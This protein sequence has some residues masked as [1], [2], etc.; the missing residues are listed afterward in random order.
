MGKETNN[1]YEFGRYRL[2]VENRT[3]FRDEQAVALPPKA[4]EL[5]AVLVER[6]GEVI[7]KERL[8]NRVWPDSFVEDANLTQN[9]FLLRKVFAEDSGRQTYIETIPRRGYRFVADVRSPAPSPLLRK[10]DPPQSPTIITKHTITQ[11]ITEAEADDTDDPGALSEELAGANSRMRLTGGRQS[12]WKVRSLR[13][14]L[15]ILLLSAVGV[16]LLISFTRP[17]H[18]GVKTVVVLPFKSLDANEGDPAMGLKLADALI[19]RLGHLRQI[20]VRPTRA[21]QKYEG[22]LSDPLVAGR[23]QQVDAVLDGSFQRAG[24]RLRLR[25]QLLRTSDGSQLWARTFDEPASDPFYL[26]DA[27][28]EQ[29]AQA[30][31]P[32]LAGAERQLVTRHDT[33]SVEAHRLYTEGR[34]YWNRRNIE[35]LQ[36]SVVYFEQAIKLD[37][38]Y[39]R[40]YAGLADSYSV[41]SDFDILRPGEAYPKIKDAALKAL[42][43]D[44]TLVEAHTSLAMLKA[45]YEW[46]WRGA[47]QAFR[48]AL[49]LN[50][51]YPTAHQWYS[52]YLA[53]MGRHEEALDEIRHAEELD[54]LSLIIRSVEAWIWYQAR[55]YDRT[56]EKCEKVLEMD[57]NFSLPYAYLGCAYERKGMYREAAEANRKRV[58]F[59]GGAGSAKPTA[60]APTSLTAKEYW[61]ARFEI[62]KPIGAAFDAAEAFAQL[63]QADQAIEMLEQAYAE[64]AY[65]LM[66]LKVHPN[67][68]PLRADPRFRDLLRRV[69]L[70]P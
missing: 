14:A 51:N 70:E 27:L 67:L 28:A 65:R 32:Q 11:I 41:M 64:H 49:E 25:V 19:Q 17:R 63:G 42:A 66:Y 16:G 20:V 37:P 38:N 22:Q 30:L 43:I 29:T 2:D 9:I 31:V 10:I 24:E 26:Q 45:S 47:E 54:P 40:A 59:M 68:D 6:H 13:F 33:E 3:L 62:L 34:Y 18:P 69:R 44:D 15:L 46:D 57:P 5:L 39:A 60:R 8:M 61:L 50:P 4:V 55:D 23:E 53:G 58:I 21:V 52:E 12:I 56:I 1:L 35:G 48:R 7:A 36:K